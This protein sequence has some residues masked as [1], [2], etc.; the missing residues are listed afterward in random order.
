MA[1]NE[2]G[3]QQQKDPKAHF[4]GDKMKGNSNVPMQRDVESR[5]TEATGK[6][7]GK[8]DPDRI[9]MDKAASNT[10]RNQTTMLTGDNPE[11]TQSPDV[12]ANV[13]PDS[14][15]AR[16]HGATYPKMHGSIG[17]RMGDSSQRGPN[18]MM[19]PNAA[20]KENPSAQNQKPNMDGHQGDKND[21]VS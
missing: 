2:T 7:V 3:K 11:Q 12:G 9:A 13:D 4:E 16:L 8:L 17:S 6:A 19:N 21:S 10:G 20:R 15:G 1:E 14:E 18:G 5:N